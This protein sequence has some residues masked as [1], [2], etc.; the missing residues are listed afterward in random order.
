MPRKVGGIEGQ[1][2]VVLPSNN[3]EDVDGGA[4]HKTDVG[5]AEFGNFEL[6]PILF[7]EVERLARG[8]FIPKE[9]HNFDAFG[10]NVNSIFHK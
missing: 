5:F 9:S 6:F 8:H 7:F 4:T 10:V 3:V 1:L 2:I